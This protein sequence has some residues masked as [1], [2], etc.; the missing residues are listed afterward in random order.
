MVYSD[1]QRAGRRMDIFN[2]RLF[3]G[4]DSNSWLLHAKSYGAAK[5]HDVFVVTYPKSG[6]LVNS[7]WGSHNCFTLAVSLSFQVYMSTGKYIARGWGTLRWTSIS[8]I[9][10]E[11]SLLEIVILCSARLLQFPS[12][13]WCV[14]GRGTSAEYLSSH[15]WKFGSGKFNV[16]EVLQYTR[17]SFRGSRNTTYSHFT[18]IG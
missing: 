16:T 11:S 7:S 12:Q 18:I 1:V 9:D 5:G 3:Y 13:G 8:S 10:T 4:K 15:R 17:I 6:K 14:V 2:Q